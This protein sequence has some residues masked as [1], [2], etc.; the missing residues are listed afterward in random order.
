VH[1]QVQPATAEGSSVTQLFAEPA[2]QAAGPDVM[3]ALHQRDEQIAELQQAVIEL[4]D[5]RAATGRAADPEHLA[6]LVDANARVET[7]EGQ[8]AEQEQTLRHV[9]TMLIEWFETS[10][11]RRAA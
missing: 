11:H 9:L 7:L 3:Q 10:D 5:M 2:A 8:I 6:A 4:A 1:A